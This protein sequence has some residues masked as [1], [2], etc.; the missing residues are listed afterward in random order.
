MKGDL[1]IGFLAVVLPALVGALGVFSLLRREC[2]RE[3]ADLREGVRARAGVLAETLWKQY[4]AGEGTGLPEQVDALARDLAREAGLASAFVWRKGKGVIWKKGE[5]QMIVRDMD[6]SY[7]WT[8]EGRRVKYP[9]RGF[10]SE[11]GTTVAWSRMG[12]RDVCGYVLDPCG[13]GRR[14]RPTARLA[15]AIGLL[16]ALVVV[17][18][19]GGWYLKRAAARAREEADALVEML[20]RKVESEEVAYV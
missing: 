17:L 7:K 12:P 4:G 5:E 11:V 19:A 2:A 15:V 9:K 10:F 3:Q 8:T 20:H 16:C 6:G 14:W 13:D 18:V 1:W